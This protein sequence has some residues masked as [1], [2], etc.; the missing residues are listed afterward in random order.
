MLHY[1]LTFSYT[2]MRTNFYDWKWP[3]ETT[4]ATTGLKIIKFDDKLLCFKVTRAKEYFTDDINGSGDYMYT[5][6]NIC[7]MIEFLIDNISVQF[8]GHLFC[9]VIGIPMVLHYLS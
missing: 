1:L 7:R 2:H 4:F 8:G 9:Q 6:D 5:A 3:Q